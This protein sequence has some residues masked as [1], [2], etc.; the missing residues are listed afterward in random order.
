MGIA[1]SKIKMYKIG[2]YAIGGVIRVVVAFDTVT[3]EFRQWGVGIPKRNVTVAN[4]PVLFEQ[5]FYHH[6]NLEMRDFI[7]DNSTCYYGSKI[8]EDIIAMSKEFIAS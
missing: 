8:L 6:D 1:K 5:L 4:S 7:E 3:I 2:E